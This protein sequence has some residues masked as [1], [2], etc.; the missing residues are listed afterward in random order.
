VA[1]ALFDSDLRIRYANEAYA[2]L[3]ERPVADHIGRKPHEVLSRRSG[4]AL[5]QVVRKVLDEGEPLVQDDFIPFRRH[6]G[7][8]YRATWY[9]VRDEATSTACGQHR[10]HHAPVAHRAWR[11]QEERTT[12]SSRTTRLARGGRQRGRP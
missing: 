3:N 12:R 2:R 4:A 5:E 1:F 11:L 7:E 10:G 8:R 9:P 6:G